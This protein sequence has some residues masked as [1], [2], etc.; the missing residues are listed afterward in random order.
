MIHWPFTDAG[1]SSLS[2]RPPLSSYQLVPSHDS[3]GQRY[4]FPSL[5]ILSPLPSLSSNKSVGQSDYCVFL[6][7]FKALH[8]K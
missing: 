5:H 4:L 6:V 7:A 1:Y 8:G 3:A 2:P